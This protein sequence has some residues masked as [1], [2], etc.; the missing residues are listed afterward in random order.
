MLKVVSLLKRAEGL[1]KEEFAKW[2]VEDHLEFAKKLPGLR[3]YTVNVAVADDA[4]YD[5]VNE[6]YFDDEEAR[7]AAFASEDG[8]AAAADAGAH[9]SSRVHVLATPHELF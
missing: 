4:P 6:L 2:V 7:V 1:S 3:K 5:A 8:K 9:T